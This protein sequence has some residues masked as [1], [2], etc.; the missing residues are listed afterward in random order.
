VTFGGLTGV[1]RRILRE[2]PLIMRELE[3][4]RVGRESVDDRVCQVG[5]DALGRPGGGEIDQSEKLDKRGYRMVREMRELRGRVEQLTEVF[6][7]TPIELPFPP[8]SEM[9]SP[10]PEL[11]REDV[12]LQSPPPAG[13]TEAKLLRPPTHSRKRLRFK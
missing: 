6:L 2:H 1:L 9:A 13:E 5:G 10:R 12:E 8:L 11:L 4:A 7:I 3:I